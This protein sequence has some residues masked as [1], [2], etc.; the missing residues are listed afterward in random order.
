MSGTPPPERGSTSLT[1]RWWWTAVVPIAL[2][3]VVVVYQLSAM[4]RGEGVW[5][6][7]V[8][9]VLGGASVGWGL[10]LLSRAWQVEQERRARDR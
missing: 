9:L 5:L 6:N 8:I 2:G 7:T 10:L 4:L 1:E 3:L